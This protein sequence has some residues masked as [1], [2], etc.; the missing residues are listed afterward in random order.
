[1]KQVFDDSRYD[2][3]N[4]I[5]SLK[6]IYQD[7]TNTWRDYFITC[8]SLIEYCK[9]GFIRFESEDAILL[10]GESQ[11]NHRHAEMYTYYLW[12]V[13][14]ESQTN[15]FK[16]FNHISYVEVKSIEED[17]YIVLNDFCY[18]RINYEVRIYYCNNDSLSKPYEIAFRK[19]KG[20]N[21]PEKYGDVINE[22]LKQ[23]DFKWNDEYKGYFFT[24]DKSDEIVEI[25]K[26]LTNKI[27][28]MN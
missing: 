22:I 5:D 1:M 6:S 12:K 21:L 15:A 23:C 13:Y 2:K 28:D 10:Y 17:A 8:P 14:F 7:K 27:I 19:S 24:S 9:Q 3:D 20:E 4:L 11:S 16:P 18:N 26:Q 25:L